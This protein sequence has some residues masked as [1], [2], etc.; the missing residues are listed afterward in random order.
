M[1]VNDIYARTEIVL[2]K[3]K[4]EKIK[5]SNICICGIGGVGSYALEALV[6][7]GVLHITIIDKD[8]VD[9]TNINRQIIATVDNVGN[10]KVEEA[11]K[12]INSINPQIDVIAI[13]DAINKENIARYITNKFDYVVD[14]ID[15]VEAKIALIKRCKEIDVPV[16]SS[17]GTANKLDPLKLKVTDI[18][19]TEVCPLAKVVRKRLRQEGINKVKVVYSTEQAVQTNTNILG[20]VSYVPSVAGL[21]IVSE[22]VKDITSK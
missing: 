10:S 5:N 8:T 7:I 17:M 22:V 6:R 2:G 3:E 21:V 1:E 19:K 12:R 18:S 16:I 14:A 11:K 9:I 4:L 20:S 15:D 13:R